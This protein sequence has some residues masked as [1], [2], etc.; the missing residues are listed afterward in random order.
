MPDCFHMRGFGNNVIL[1]SHKTTIRLTACLSYSRGH[2]ENCTIYVV[3][4][5]ST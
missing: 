3:S 5:D 2:P 1:Q 4:T